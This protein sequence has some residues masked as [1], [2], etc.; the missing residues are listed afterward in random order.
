MN[1]LDRIECN[2]ECHFYCIC[3]DIRIAAGL[4]IS[5]VYFA[6]CGFDSYFWGWFLLVIGGICLFAVVILM[7]KRKKQIRAIQKVYAR[8]CK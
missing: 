1:Q 3:Y 7:I 6:L 4:I 8:R 2:Q 5:L